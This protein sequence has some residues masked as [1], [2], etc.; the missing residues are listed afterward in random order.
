MRI[1]RKSITEQVYNI[2]QKGIENGTL[3]PGERIREDK[4]AAKLAVSKTPLRIALHQLKES[5]LVRI[6]PRLGIYLAVPS[7]SEVA[8]LI[9]MREVLEGLAARHAARKICD[10]QIAKLRGCFSAFEENT[11]ANDRQAYAAADHKFHRLL[12]AASESPELINSLKIINLRLHLNRLR[13]SYTR[14]HDLRPIH[15]EH[16]A[17]ID[18]L[19]AGN[20]ATAERLMR[21]HIHNIPWQMVI[22]EAEEKKTSAA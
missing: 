7:E 5:G 19:A 10:K 2:L 4:L 22:S 16:L 20:A 12:V 18:A 11:L 13:M 6:D 1:Q 9:E 14:A 8:T 17:I 21:A 3:K 15:R